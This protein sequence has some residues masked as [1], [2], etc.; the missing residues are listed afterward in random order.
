MNGINST[1]ML[2]RSFKRNLLNDRSIKIPP[3]VEFLR[4]KK[5]QFG[6]FIVS[7]QLSEQYTILM[8]D[9]FNEL[10]S[11]DNPQKQQLLICLT[12]IIIDNILPDS[13]MDQQFDD[14]QYKVPNER[15]VHI[16]N[17]FE[18]INTLLEISH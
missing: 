12:T 1:R 11:D 6:E 10:L 4:R 8:T 9:V 15:L 16:F 2:S 7:L 17:L 3:Q 13:T 5:K 18:S 14:D